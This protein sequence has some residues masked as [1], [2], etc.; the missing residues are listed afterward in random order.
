MNFELPKVQAPA[1]ARVFGGIRQFC[2][3]DINL[4]AMICRWDAMSDGKWVYY[5]AKLEPELPENVAPEQKRDLLMLEA[6]KH[7]EKAIS[8]TRAMLFN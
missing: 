6:D 8:A 1:F 3:Y 5:D 4:D 7:H 2:M